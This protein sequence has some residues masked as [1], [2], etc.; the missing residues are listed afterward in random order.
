METT[1]DRLASA[2]IGKLL[3]ALAIPNIFAQ[4]VNMLYNIVDRIYIGRIPDVGADA[5]TGVGVGF[6]I[7][8]I[9]TAFSSLV[10]M[11]GAPQAAIKLGE[12]KKDEAEKILGNSIALL[13]ALSI[14]LTAVFLIFGRDL[15]FMFGASHQTIDYA[16]D[17]IKIVIIGSVAIQFALGLNPYIATQGFAKYSMLTVL[18]GA[19]LNIVLDP[20]LIFGFDM[21]VKGAAIATVFSQAVSAVWVMQFLTGKKSTLKIHP[22]Y[23]RL[24]KSYVILIISL[25]VSPFIMQSTESLLNITFNTSLQK[26]G[27]D[28]NVGAMTITASL[29]QILMLPLMGLTQGA[30]PIISYNFGANKF[31]RVKKAFKYLFISSIAYSTIFWIVVQFFPNIFIALFTSDPS[32]VEVTTNNMRIYMG[33]VFMF[34]AQIACQQTFI[35][36]GQARMSLFLALLRKVILLIPLILILP[37]FFTNKVFG[38]LVAEPIADFIAVAVTV[39]IF[40]S[41]F[42]KILKEKEMKQQSI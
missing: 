12:G 2:P 31:D 42:N 28:L 29:M 9:I 23:I 3:F 17:Y 41:N 5:L 11:G 36:L 22:K 18:I 24:K 16:W 27:G 35:A 25:G 1:T 13:I 19:V 30:Q 10:G 38:V 6:P 15:L 39:I 14:L 7:F 40:F 4:L 20:I 26:Y 21:G 33:V 32:L 8:M 34:G 37:F